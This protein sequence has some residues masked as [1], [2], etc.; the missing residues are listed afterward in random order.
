MKWFNPKKIRRL[1]WLEDR[2]F[3]YEVG[4][5]LIDM[6][7]GA[8]GAFLVYRIALWNIDLSPV[9][10]K[11]ATLRGGLVQ[12]RFLDAGKGLFNLLA[13][14]PF[15]SLRLLGQHGSFRLLRPGL[16]RAKAKPPLDSRDQTYKFDHLQA[17]RELCLRANG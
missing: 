7:W 16:C 10:S 12:I 17:G 3:R 13:G 1:N 9:A 6:V 11:P 8:V 4:I 5:L 2:L 14:A 15:L